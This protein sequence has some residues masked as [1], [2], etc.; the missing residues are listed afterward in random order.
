VQVREAGDAPAGRGSAPVT[1]VGQGVPVVL[2]GTTAFDRWQ[3]ANVVRG[4]AK[5]TVSAI[6]WSRLG[7]V[8]AAQFRGIA[9]IARELD[10]E[11]RITNRQNFALRGLVE[12]QLPELH[13]RLD[14]LGMAQPGAELGRDV[15]A[16]PGADT[17]NLAVTQSR[18][19]ASAI[20][21][22][23]DAAGLAEVDGVRINISGCTNSCGQHHVAD[24]GFFGAERRAHGTSA[25]GYQMLLG[26][27]VGNEQVVF[28]QKALRLPART[29]PEAA[30]R[31]VGRYAAEREHAE[32][33]ASWLA[34][35][36]GASEVAAGLVD[37]AEFPTPEDDPDF[38][39]D[40]GETGPYVKAVGDSECAA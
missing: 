32:S 29:A 7:D 5:Q 33:F 16:C 36:G 15:V 37:L 2:R 30:T 35:V 28:A 22:A 25:P 6:A 39:V 27:Y 8:T 34:R 24:I 4:A 10:V 31:V 38:Y 23:L 21:D 14:Q 1:G 40:F 9:T 20:G 13:Q 17:C 18:G 12:D 3:Q 11:V 19:L 26:G